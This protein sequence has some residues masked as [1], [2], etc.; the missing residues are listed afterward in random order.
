MTVRITLPTGMG[1]RDWADQVALDLDNYG[2]LGRLDDVENWQNW[3]MQFL[4]NTTLGR[5]FP[6]PYDF[7]DWRDW[8]ERFCQTA[9]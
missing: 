3:A 5:N 8:A 4:N 7:D 2:A 1:L 6:L 9:E